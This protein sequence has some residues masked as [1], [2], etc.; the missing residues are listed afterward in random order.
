MKKATPVA[1]PSSLALAMGPPLV[2]PTAL[3]CLRCQLIG[4][5]K[6]LCARADA[7]RE[8]PHVF[9]LGPVLLL[10]WVATIVAFILAVA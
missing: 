10:A 3:G 6:L 8:I 7:C 4:R 2:A 1:A 5:R 9:A